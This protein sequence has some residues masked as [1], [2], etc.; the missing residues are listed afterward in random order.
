M[1]ETLR[2]IH[3]AVGGL[4]LLLTL[5]AAATLLLMART[6]TPG[7]ALIL[8]GTLV[9]AS[10]QGLL[11]ITLLILAAV[12]FGTGYFAGWLWLH[13]LLGLAAVGLVSVVTARARR[14]PDSEARRYGSM[15]L[16]VLVVV[17]L[18]FLVGQFRIGS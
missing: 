17:L 7:P 4:T 10:L 2:T 18:A 8:R 14:A 3:N 12:F 13:I 6:S 11:G 1:Y 9:S 16:G 5:V 15:L